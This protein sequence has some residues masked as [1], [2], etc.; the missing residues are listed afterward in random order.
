MRIYEGVT[1]DG[2]LEPRNFVPICGAE[3][4]F[5]GVG[6]LTTQL[7]FH[8]SARLEPSAVALYPRIYYCHATRPHSLLLV[9]LAYLFAP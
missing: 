7:Y 8:P 3:S 2:G 1:S 4:L 5:H 9:L 6:A